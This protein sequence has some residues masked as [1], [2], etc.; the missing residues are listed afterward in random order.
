[1]RFVRKIANSDM[2]ADIIDIPE[3]LRNKQVEIII[4]PYEDPENKNIKEDKGKNARGILE[5]YKNE[6]L[7]EKENEAWANAVV[8]K[9]ENS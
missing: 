1:M 4:L 8:E 5:R 6:R 9:H 3:E 2:L 7:Q